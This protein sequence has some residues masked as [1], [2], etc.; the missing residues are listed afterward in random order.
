MNNQKEE[1]Q[2]APKWDAELSG[3]PAPPP[4]H[5]PSISHL[6]LTGCKEEGRKDLSSV[7]MLE[8]GVREKR[9]NLEVLN[10][11]LF[12]TA[13]DFEGWF[14]ELEAVVKGNV[15]LMDQY[16]ELR[17]APNGDTYQREER[18]T[19]VL[20]K[21]LLLL[22]KADQDPMVTDQPLLWVISNQLLQ[23]VN[24][25][26]MMP[27]QPFCKFAMLAGVSALLHMGFS[28]NTTDGG[29]F[30]G[31]HYSI[32]QI[33]YSL[34]YLFSRW[35]AQLDHLSSRP[36]SV[37]PL[38]LS[39]ERRD[40]NAARL[41]LALGADVN[42]G[43]DT[44]VSPLMKT[45]GFYS[46]DMFRL[47][48]GQGADRAT[49]DKMGNSLLHHAAING[50]LSDIS[51]SFSVEVLREGNSKGQTPLHLAVL[52]KKEDA[53]KFLLDKG[54][55]LEVCDE[56]G[57]TA[58]DYAAQMWNVNLFNQLL[59]HVTGGVDHRE[60]FE[61]RYTLDDK[62]LRGGKREEAVEYVKSLPKTRAQFCFARDPDMERDI[63]YGFPNT[64]LQS[65]ASHGPREARKALLTVVLDKCLHGNNVVR[66]NCLETDHKGFVAGTLYKESGLKGDGG[67]E[68]ER[69]EVRKRRFDNKSESLLATLTKDEPLFRSMAH[70]PTL[71]IFM[72]NKWNK[73][74]FYYFLVFLLAYLFRMLFLTLSLGI[75]A[76][77]SLLDPASYNTPLDIFRLVCE[78]ITLLIILGMIVA[79]IVNI[80]GLGKSYCS[81]QEFFSFVNWLAIFFTLLIIP[82][83]ATSTKEQW[84]IASIAYFFHGLRAFEFAALFRLTGVYV[85]TLRY[86]FKEDVLKFVTI[87]IVVL[88]LFMGCLGLALRD[89][90]DT[91][92]QS[93]SSQN[94]TLPEDF[95]SAFYDL[96]YIGLRTMIQASSVWNYVVFRWLGVI[97]YLSFL[98]VVVTVLLNVLIAQMT[99]TYARVQA[100]ALTTYLYLRALFIVKVERKYHLWSL[101]KHCER[102][103]VREE[104]FENLL[105]I[106]IF[107]E[108]T[109]LRGSLVKAK[110]F[111]QRLVS[112][113]SHV[114]M[115]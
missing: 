70:H 78:T 112:V 84:I 82:L 41:L 102:R 103:T 5:H 28:P 44:G 101:F 51:T 10:A 35:G 6:Y 83:R 56:E 90:L 24:Q 29:G 3:I 114:N 54:V 23:Y 20:G 60:V 97:V 42:A 94:V 96:Y 66:A 67:A 98:F 49:L 71:M 2:N 46:S 31:I 88:L 18:L 77:P 106:D 22:W 9:L 74:G 52:H 27:K 100:S 37:T 108:E 40:T 39:I 47:L 19:L 32:Q 92:Y 61:M 81:F 68:G 58:L 57:N 33:R 69:E 113:E 36:F 55:G 80:I 64:S 63:G 110:R 62:C 85:Q 76:R 53:I 11:V 50:R 25:I 95:T 45:L 115:V 8:A 34:L 14:R 105:W 72:D 1:V 30:N 87:F 17:E 109:G 79:E 93:S 4:F 38:L 99:D 59:S 75:A 73:F 16:K 13:T 12:S 48:L 104:A 91:A 89:D 26:M 15:V 21:S 65:L 107:K 111:L 43:D 7:E 86:I